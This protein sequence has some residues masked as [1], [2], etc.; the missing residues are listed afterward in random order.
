MLFWL[1][2][3][4][5]ILLVCGT[6]LKEFMERLPM[7]VLAAVAGKSLHI[8]FDK[9]L[10]N[11]LVK[12]EQN[13]MVRTI[14]IFEL[15][16]QKWLTICYKV[17]TPFWKTFLWLKQLFDAKLIN[18][19]TIIFKCSEN[20]GRPSPTRVTRLNVAPNM[21]VLTKKTIALISGYVFLD[22]QHYDSVKLLIY[23]R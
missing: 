21:A 16:D 22:L 3:F 14:Q 12:I 23:K 13:R 7:S 2:D 4:V 18:S 17:L 8:L 15:F 11:M 6:I 1:Y 9:Y 19:K 20:Y 10:D 5:Q